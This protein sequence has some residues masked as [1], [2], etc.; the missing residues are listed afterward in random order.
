MLTMDAVGNGGGG[1]V[2]GFVGGGQGERY[3][4]NQ[5]DHR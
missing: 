4:Q 5:D 1:Q 2:E 3:G